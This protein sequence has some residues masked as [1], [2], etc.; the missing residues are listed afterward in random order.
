[1]DKQPKR[2][3]QYTAELWEKR[4]QETIEEDVVNQW[5]LQAGKGLTSPSGEMPSEE[6]KLIQDNMMRQNLLSIGNALPDR[7]KVMMLRSFFKHKRNQ[8]VEVFY[9]K[10][11]IPERQLGKVNVIGRDFVGLTSLKER[12]WLPY[13]VIE[14]A[15]IPYGLPDISS[16][17][18]HIVFDEELRQKLLTRFGETVAGRDVLIQQFFEES[19]QTH[20]MTWRGSRVEVTVN[21]ERLTGKIHRCE[22]GQLVLKKWG[23]ETVIAL[24]DITC[25]RTLRWLQLLPFGSK[26]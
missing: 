12:V 21:K 3:D 13:R 10:D 11:G 22:D 14:S 26:K 23:S 25:L 8:L 2:L 7:K 19:L 18:Q 1:M 20:L 16:T 4:R 9:K 24:G 15:N 5:S 6:L 17:H